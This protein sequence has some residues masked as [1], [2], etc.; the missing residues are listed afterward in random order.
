MR[1]WQLA[2]YKLST[3]SERLDQA[4]TRN[5]Q[6][7]PWRRRGEIVYTNARDGNRTENL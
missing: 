2:F 5:A 1:R 7:G 6:D 3:P 4:V